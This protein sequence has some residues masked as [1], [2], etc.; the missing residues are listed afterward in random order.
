MSYSRAAYPNRPD[1]RGRPKS[2][3]HATKKSRIF[4]EK[5]VPNP[6]KKVAE[7][8]ATF[9]GCKIGHCPPEMRQFLDNNAHNK[10]AVKFHDGK[11]TVT[12][13]I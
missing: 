2:S 5:A 3:H 4:F 10:V 13:L 12:A 8:P 1:K 9:V 7:K 6:E 11:G